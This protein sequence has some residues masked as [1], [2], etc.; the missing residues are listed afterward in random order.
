MRE[1]QGRVGFIAFARGNHTLRLVGPEICS[2][3]ATGIVWFKTCSCMSVK[4]MHSRFGPM[5]RRRCLGASLLRY[6][7]I[8]SYLK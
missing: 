6:E 8:V 5:C 1:A 7:V 3:F 4:N 2:E